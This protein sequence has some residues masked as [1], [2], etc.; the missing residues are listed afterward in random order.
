MGLLTY[1]P[2]LLVIMRHL[3]HYIAAHRE[4][5]LQVVGSE[6][7]ATLDAVVTACQAF[8]AIAVAFAPHGS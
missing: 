3:C 5:I 8:E 2:T 4:R 7:T 1:I 6:H